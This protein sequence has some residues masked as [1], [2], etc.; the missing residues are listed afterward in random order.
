MSQ[1]FPWLMQRSPAIL[2]GISLIVLAIGVVVA[3]MTSL[4]TSEQVSRAPLN[5]LSNSGHTIAR[6]QLF[7]GLYGALQSASWP[8]A[9]AA[10]V[11][12]L[13]SRAKL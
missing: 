8:F 11:Y 12:A 10:I 13:Q 1:V 6:I 3:V 9:A 5:L 2:F 4:A 7:S